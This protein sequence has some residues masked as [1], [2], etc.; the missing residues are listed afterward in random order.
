MAYENRDYTHLSENEKQKIELI[1]QAIRNKAY[2]IDVRESIALAIEWVNREY[3]L[4]IENNIL[5]LKEFENAKAKVSTLELDMDEFI[6]RYSEQI[7]GNTSLDETIDARTDATGVSHT[8]LK[9]RLDKDQQEVSAQLAQTERR[10]RKHISE[11]SSVQEAF[12]SGEPL[13]ITKGV[14]LTSDLTIPSNSDIEADEGSVLK[15]NTTADVFVSIT[16]NNVRI[17][18]VTFDCDNSSRMGVRVTAGKKDVS[19]KGNIIK[20]CYSDT[21]QTAGI[22]IDGET[23]NIEVSNC[24]IDNIVSVSDGN[25]GNPQGASRGVLIA[26]LSSEGVCKNIRLANNVIKNIL[27]R[28][29]G[30]GVVI[31]GWSVRTN[32]T[33]SENFFTNCAKRAVKIMSPGV[34]VTKNRIENPYTHVSDYNQVMYSYISIYAGET[35]ISENQCFGGN[36]AHG[37]DVGT[38]LIAVPKNVKVINNEFILSEIGVQPTNG[39]VVAI[40][41]IENF[42]VSG[43]TI[44]NA[45]VGVFL[46]VRAIGVTISDNTILNANIGIRID[47][48]NY[49][50]IRNVI[51]DGNT[52]H[53]VNQAMRLQAGQAIVR[54]NTGEYG[55]VWQFV[56]IAGTAEARLTGNVSDIYYSLPTP[57]AFYRDLIITVRNVNVGDE[58]YVCLLNA[59]NT[60]FS[61]NKIYQQTVQ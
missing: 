5:T 28:E 8:T 45:N 60:T 21:N 34:I 17:S 56:D 2:G 44:S 24:T 33:I 47:S 42:I 26:P 49:S 35:I 50:D 52:I 61:W 29:D 22:R 53:S 10:T 31:Q 19:L 39:M 11:F 59:D 57:T 40:S 20:N 12:D 36:V 1:A 18:G 6:Q 41:N 23:E 51:I 16:G 30:D 9:D 54:G 58:V 46:R 4:T 25:V 7:A 43:N 32:V 27:P 55:K 37:I 3:K 38:D 14:Y 48:F 13:K 15:L